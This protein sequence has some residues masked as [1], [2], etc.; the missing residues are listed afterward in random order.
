MSEDQSTFKASSFPS[1][2]CLRCRGHNLANSGREPH[3]L[4]C[5]DCNANYFVV[6]KMVEVPAVNEQALLLEPSIVTSSE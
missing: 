3:R 6:M 4:I 2:R 1:L 5:S